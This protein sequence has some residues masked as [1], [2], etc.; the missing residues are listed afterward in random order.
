[1][2]QSSLF[3]LVDGI[4]L[5]QR[6]TQC[7][8]ANNS[9]LVTNRMDGV[10]PVGADLFFAGFAPGNE[11]DKIGQPMTGAN[12]R[13]FRE[14]LKEAGLDP[15]R[16]FITNCLKCALY[17]QKAHDKHW[18][19]CKTH[20]K[21]ELARIKPK[22]IVAVGAQALTWLTG[23][24]GIKNLRKHGLPCEVDDQLLVFPIWQPA[25]L[26]HATSEGQKER[27]RSEMIEDLI[28]LRKRAESGEL[29][30]QDELPVNYKT[31][32]TIQDVRDFVEEIKK[33]EWVYADLETCDA[34]FQKG[35]LI[36]EDGVIEAVGF[37]YG[38]Q[39]G[40]AIPYIA[41]GVYTP[42]YWTENEFAE[43]KELIREVWLTKKIVGQHFGK[44]DQ[45]WIHKEWGIPHVN[46]V[47]DTHLASYIHEPAR[48]EH[49]L[50]SLART[51]TDMAPWKKMFTPNDLPKLCYYLCK[52][53]DASARVTL[54][55]HSRLTSK[56]HQLLTDLYIPLVHA[57][58]DMEYK[59]TKVSEEALKELD[60]YL[61]VR[62]GE[63]LT[64]LRAI[65]EVQQ[66]EFA[67]NTA[68][69]PNADRQIGKILG[70]YMKLP[71][72]KTAS[73]N[74]YSTAKGTLDAFQHIPLVQL[75]SEYSRLDK[76]HGTYCRGIRERLRKGRIH[77]TFRT[78]TVSGRLASEDPNLQNI[79]RR[80]TAGKVMDD[81][82]AIKK[83]FIPDDGYV[84]IDGDL[85]QA[86]LRVLC[87]YSKDKNLIKIFEEDRDAHTATAAK[88]YGIPES[89]VTEAQRN[90]AKPV[91]F[92]IIYGRHES[93]ICS[94]M[95]D[96][97]VEMW[98]KGKIYQDRPEQW[99]RNKG[100]Q[101][102]REFVAS[103]KREF[104]D[105]WRWMNAQEQ[106]IRA[107]LYQETLLGWRRYW[108][109][110]DDAAIREAYNLPIQSTAS[111]ITLMALHTLHSIFQN[112]GID[113]HI[114]LTVHDSIL[115]QAH[116]SIAWE[117][118]DIMKCVMQ[119]K[120]WDWMITPMKVDL[121]MGLSYGDMRKISVAERKV[122]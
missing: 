108:D 113:A 20:L 116:N 19:E 73:G 99:V 107:H 101:D 55:L 94:Q 92:G 111:H 98:K 75:V 32:K 38:P 31:A 77:T 41:P 114:L 54:A 121:K 44:F 59:G 45:K 33:A 40:R 42:L 72:P 60:I 12:G 63:V 13:L 62:E 61:T 53:V 14:L 65:P 26:W 95:A 112:N 35:V 81:A 16:Q 64:K 3:N 83:L 84:L 76:L 117:V 88:C 49:G 1:M 97:M 103:H 52:D 106:Q 78:K 66:F 50:E 11:D 24:S 21:G 93:T 51:Y 28:W 5:Q 18:K 25:Q 39:H 57:L 48:K 15:D 90:L 2:A 22:A 119:T 17:E 91:S 100:T 43:I 71:L 9:G 87:Y 56:Q 89:E 4:V 109:F 36:P 27:L 102:G 104:I 47:F 7:D 29:G 80:E 46:L 30:R 37:S 105:V 58:K 6:C 120:F 23:E 69:N 8:L 10:G 67:E 86:E 82:N 34:K 96:A 68:F 122:F 85:S 79:P 115:V 70:E 74:Q 110:I 118:A